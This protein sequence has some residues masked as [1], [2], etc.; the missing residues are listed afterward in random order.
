MNI[1]EAVKS[2]FN[3]RLVY[4]DKWLVCELGSVDEFVVYQ[5]KYGSRASRASREVYRGTDENEAVAELLKD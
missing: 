4:A 3:A 1:Q 2:H 5:R